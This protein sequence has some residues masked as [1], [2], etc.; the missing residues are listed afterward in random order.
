MNAGLSAKTVELCIVA[1]HECRAGLLS[2]K[3]HGWVTVRR[4]RIAKAAPPS[5]AVSG[6]TNNT[7]ACAGVRKGRRRFRT[8][9]PLE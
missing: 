1:I 9:N 5:S 3:G 7:P 4:G 2:I 6:M 8:S